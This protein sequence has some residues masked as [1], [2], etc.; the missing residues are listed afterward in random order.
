MAV[1]LLE[2]ML[3]CWN[4]GVDVLAINFLAKLVTGA[5]IVFQ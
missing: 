1:E 5:C 4:S 3:K 2:D